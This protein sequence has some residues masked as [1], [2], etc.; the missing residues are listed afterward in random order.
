[1]SDFSPKKMAEALVEK[2][3]RFI[4]EYSDDVEKAQQMTMLREKRDQLHHWLAENGSK[5][6]FKK[7]LEDT[8]KELKNLQTAFK[9]KNQAH[10]AALKENI[11][12][13]KKARDYWQSRIGEIKS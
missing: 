8:D 3:T 7:E 1:M 9:P 13:H 5:E 12:E 2:H 4:S 11:G 6:K 10:Y